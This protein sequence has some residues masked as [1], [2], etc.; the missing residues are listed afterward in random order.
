MKLSSA[1]T[2]TISG[3]LLAG[4]TY[5]STTSQVCQGSITSGYTCGKGTISSLFS[6]GKLTMDGTVDQGYLTVLGKSEIS[7]AQINGKATLD[8]EFSAQNDTFA[9]DMS[10]GTNKGVFI[11]S[12]TKDIVLTEG[13]NLYLQS[14]THVNGSITFNQGNGTVYVSG[15]STI[16]GKVNGGKIVNK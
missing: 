12:T 11:G 5:A 8:G 9:G 1:I 16:S 2:L 13:Q 7:N 3:L 15:G 14:A 10:L 4:A 6:M